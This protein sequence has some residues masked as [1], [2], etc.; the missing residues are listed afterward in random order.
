MEYPYQ[1]V[2]FLDTE[3]IERQLIYGDESGGWLAQIA[4]KRRFALQDMNEDQLI[5]KLGSFCAS[6]ESFELRAL[7]V[8]KP[9][10]MPVEVIMVDQPNAAEAFHL[11]FLRQFDQNIASKYPE[12]EGEA[13]FP[14]ITAEYWDKRVIDVTR[15]ENR[16]FPIRSVWLVKDDPGTQDT[17]ALHGVE[18]KPSE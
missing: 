6:I 1:I 5:Q 9:E 13:Y 15:Y 3:P 12:R 16:T 18:L 10:R 2:T 17:R 11:E 7:T 4:L 14:H 8:Q